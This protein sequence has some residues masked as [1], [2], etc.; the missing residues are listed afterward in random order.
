M[1][2]TVSVA[3]AKSNFSNILDR[4]SRRHVRVVVSKRGK[5][6]GAIVNADDLSRLEE[7][8][9]QE[10][11]RQVR[12]VKESTTEYV[13]YGKFVEEYE[14]RWGVDLETKPE[15]KVVRD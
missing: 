8:E 13:P 15:E 11:L 9:K 1:V 6:V 7:M 2:K 4:V 14:K 12:A 3:E 5:P 10:R